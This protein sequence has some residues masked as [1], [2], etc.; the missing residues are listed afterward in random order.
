[1]EGFLKGEPCNRNGCSGIIDE[2]DT[3]TSCSCHVNPPCSHCTTD[4]N[5]CPVCG[6]EGRDEQQAYTPSEKER[7]YYEEETK[8]WQ[9][10]RNAF[11][12]QYSGQ[13]IITG[14]KIIHE[15]HTHFS[16]IFRGVF[17]DGSETAASILPHVKGSF[18]GRFEVFTS[19]KFKYIAYTD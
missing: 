12:R 6:W 5:Y 19:T 3:D 11:E 8:R 13:E 9:E 17:P 4:R 1:M 18:G 16:Q 2:H 14:L 7:A 10:E 15:Y